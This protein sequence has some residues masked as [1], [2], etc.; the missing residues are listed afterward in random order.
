LR[1]F[2]MAGNKGGRAGTKRAIGAATPPRPFLFSSRTWTESDREEIAIALDQAKLAPDRARA[3]VDGW[4]LRLPGVVASSLQRWRLAGGAQRVRAGRTD[5][6]DVR[7]WGAY[8]RPGWTWR[9]A[10]PD[11]ATRCTV[12]DPGHGRSRARP[13]SDDG[14][15]TK[16]RIV[17]V[18]DC[19]AG[20]GRMT[21]RACS[22]LGGR[23]PGPAGDG[24]GTA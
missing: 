16:E 6:G 2:L 7:F 13:S 3:R 11:H 22:R 23:V 5:H 8:I 24:A 18:C 14:D 1:V 17:R 9:P 15:G 12:P 19:E 21:G 10:G 20:R 4:Q